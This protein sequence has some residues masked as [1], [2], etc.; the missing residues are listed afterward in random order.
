MRNNCLG[1]GRE[2]KAGY[3]VCTTTIFDRPQGVRSRV[4]VER[5][6]WGHAF[7]CYY[8][9]ISWMWSRRYLDRRLPGAGVLAFELFAR[10]DFTFDRVLA[11]SFPK[12]RM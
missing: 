3:L 12:N 5:W 2:V 10:Q 8:S 9:R 4:C 1:V 6:T 7:D 11:E